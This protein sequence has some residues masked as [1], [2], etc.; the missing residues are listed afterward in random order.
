MMYRPQFLLE[1]EEEASF[2]FC[3][4]LLAIDIFLQT[5]KDI[6]NYHFLNQ[7]SSGRYQFQCHC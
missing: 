3:S 2:D 4:V 1:H 6:E 7:F 5:L